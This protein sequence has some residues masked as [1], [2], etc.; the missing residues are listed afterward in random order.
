MDSIFLLLCVLSKAGIILCC[1]GCAIFGITEVPTDGVEF[2]T[3]NFVMDAAAD[4]LESSPVAAPLGT[5][6]DAPTPQDGTLSPAA[7]TGSPG[8]DLESGE[9]SHVPPPESNTQDLI[10][11]TQPGSQ[12]LSTPQQPSDSQQSSVNDLD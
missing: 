11:S 12:L 7:N 9:Q 6:Y 4:S 1:L 2:D 3:E 8:V 10:P 5:N